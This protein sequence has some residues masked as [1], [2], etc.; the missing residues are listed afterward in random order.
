MNALI[1]MYCRCGDLDDGK[2]L[3]EVLEE[4]SLVSWN[5]LITGYRY[6]S[7]GNEALVLFGEMR[8]AGLRPNHLT[9]LNLLPVCQ[10]LLQG[11]SIHAY[12]VRTG[13]NHEI[14]SLLLLCKCML[15]LGIY[16]FLR[17]CFDWRKGGI[18]PSGMPIYLCI[19]KQKMPNKQS[20]HFAN[21][22][23]QGRAGLLN[24]AF[25]YVKRLPCKP[26]TSLL[27]SLLGAC[28]IHGNVELGEEISKMVLDIDTD[29]VGSY[30]CCIICMLQW[31]GGKMP[32]E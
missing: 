5:A 27:E 15:D 29:N 1:A 12:A 11:K 9:L 7:L 8:K 18:Y 13:I 4:P 22:L 31:E 25:N 2:L 30:I 6:H 23:T 28:G 16:T 24:E 3:F 17:P 20:S 14:S 32:I 19:S 26:S 21:C 10:A